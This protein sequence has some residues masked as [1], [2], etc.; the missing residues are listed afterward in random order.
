MSIRYL[1]AE[2]AK[3]YWKNDVRTS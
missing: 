2:R 1:R 3:K